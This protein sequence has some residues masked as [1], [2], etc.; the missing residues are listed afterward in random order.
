MITAITGKPGTGKTWIMSQM[1][2]RDLINGEPVFINYALLS[3]KKEFFCRDCQDYADEHEIEDLDYDTRYLRSDEVGQM[4]CEKHPNTKFI[5]ERYIPLT[6][7]DYP[8]LTYWKEVNEWRKF[9]RGKIYIDEGQIFFNSRNWEQLPLLIQYKLQLHRHDGLDLILTTQNINRIDIIV[10][11]LIGELYIADKFFEAFDFA[12]FT[13]TKLDTDDITKELKKVEKKKWLLAN[14]RDRPIYDTLGKIP[15]PIAK[16]YTRQ[17]V[18]CKE[19]G[20]EHPVR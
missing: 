4:S 15:L 18:K 7:D 5:L 19:C 16:G 1:A 9:K 2:I 3:D 10:R 17:F 14:W 8:N 11:E 12:L 20:K 13:K 6:K